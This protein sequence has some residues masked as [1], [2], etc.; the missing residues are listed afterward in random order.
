[1]NE[2]QV[3]TKK[4]LTKKDIRRTWMLWLGTCE[5]SNSFE[6]LQSLSFVGCLAPILKKLY[7]DDEELSLA[8]K[9][10]LT[11]FNTEG[12][13]GS[14]IHG[15]VI[16]ME[17]ERA[18]GEEISDDMIT[19]LKTGF[20]G[21]LAGIGDTVD[22]GTIRPIV[23]GLFLPLAS[24]GS[25]IA[26]L[27]PFVV[28]SL[29]TS[30]ISYYLWH[31]GY[32]VGRKSI[33]QVLKDGRINQFIMASSILGMFMMGILSS[34]YV[35]LELKPFLMVNGEKTTIQSYVDQILP[36]LLPIAAVFIL[37]YLIKK[38]NVKYTTILLGVLVFSLLGALVGLF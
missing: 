36:G 28:V 20:M 24:A 29:I 19:G 15:I 4:L 12:I 9:R 13:W 6:R 11:F 21:P 27:G 2:N 16:A 3:D 1:M 35:K 5:L 38:R 37:Y 31:L 14:L 26:G 18:K 34:Q 30:T 7:K 17:E 23:I 32:K 8:F 33:L 10:H 22:W 25:W